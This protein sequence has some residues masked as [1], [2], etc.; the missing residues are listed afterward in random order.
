M[1]KAQLL[2][3]PGYDMPTR[4]QL[5][6]IA[7]RLQQH[8]SG[9]I[10]G[11]H[12][13]GGRTGKSWHKG[14]LSI[15]EAL[16]T[17]Q[18][19]LTRGLNP[20]GD[21]HIWYQDKLIVC[22]HYRILAG[23]AQLRESFTDIYR[24]IETDIQRR[25]HQVEPNDLGAICYVLKKPYVEI[26]TACL[27]SGLNRWD[28]LATSATCAIGI[29]K[30][31]E[32]FKDNGQPIR[33]PKGWSWEQRAEVRAF[34]NAVGRSHGTPTIP[35]IRAL[36]RQLNP[37]LDPEALASPDFDPS[38]PPEAQARNLAMIQAQ[39]PGGP[40]SALSQAQRVELLRGKEEDGID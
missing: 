27:A 17:V 28:A 11:I 14:T 24:T 38:L 26:F 30:H 18:F 29:V 34:R 16:Y 19:A 37:D 12:P 8:T 4:D 22:E 25:R 10:A 32:M 33:P 5:Y 21:I 23:W 7:A 9:T 35:E 40:A 13:D 2:N 6:T 39:Q 3:N 1:P 36:A 31:S 15:D 20:F